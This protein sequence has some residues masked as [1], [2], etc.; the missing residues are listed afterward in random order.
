M[1]RRWGRVLCKTF[2]AIVVETCGKSAIS[3]TAGPTDAMDIFVDVVREIVIDDVH[4][5]LDIETPGCDVGGNENRC[6]PIA[7]SNHCVL[8]I[9]NISQKIEGG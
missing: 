8:R 7:E 6:F 2:V 5:V 3:D 9:R 1:V 4:D